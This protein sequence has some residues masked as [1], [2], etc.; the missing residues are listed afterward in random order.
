M[1]TIRQNKV[2]RLLQKE[3]S[4]ILQLNTN[5]WFPGTMVSV[6]IIRISPDLSFAKV[7]LSIFGKIEPTDGINIANSHVNEVRGALGKIVGK[8]LRITPEIAF[9]LDDSIDY[10]EEIE[11][12]LKK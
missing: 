7:Y 3:L 1:S 4:N 12:L 6:T 5:E 10:A 2:A 11:A 9:Y 8:Q